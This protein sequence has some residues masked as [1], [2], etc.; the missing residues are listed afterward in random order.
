[1]NTAWAAF[2]ASYES[3]DTNVAKTRR[4]GVA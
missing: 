2:A 4:R 1:V 3:T